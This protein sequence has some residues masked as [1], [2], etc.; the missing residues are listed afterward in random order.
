[1]TGQEEYPRFISNRP[2]GIDKYEGKSQ[3][4]EGLE[5][6][7]IK[8]WQAIDGRLSSH[9]EHCLIVGSL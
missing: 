7:Q 6:L 3:E 2:C 9:M 4:P 1:M 8:I 5:I